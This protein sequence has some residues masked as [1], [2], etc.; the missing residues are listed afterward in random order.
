MK[1]LIL[2]LMMSVLMASCAHHLVGEKL[3]PSYCNS[4]TQKEKQHYKDSKNSVFKYKHFIHEENNSITFAGY[5]IF[6]RNQIGSGPNI[7]ELQIDLLFCDENYVVI[8]SEQINFY[9]KEVAKPISFKRTFPY[10]KRYKHV[11]LTWHALLD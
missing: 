8:A 11:F 3:N 1:K 7:L 4:L 9:N 6:K 2:L 5:L 10:D